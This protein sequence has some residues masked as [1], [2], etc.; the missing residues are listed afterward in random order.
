M[1]VGVSVTLRG[2]KMWEELGI[3]DEKSKLKSQ[4]LKL[5]DEIFEDTLEGKR[6]KKNT[7]ICR[8]ILGI[9]RTWSWK[10]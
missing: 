3:I 8:L 7:N 5:I 10:F 2:E 4:E 9:L 6:L 1:E